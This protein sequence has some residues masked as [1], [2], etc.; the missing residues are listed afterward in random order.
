M[1][2]IL[3]ILGLSSLG[4]VGVLGVENVK[5]IFSSVRESAERSLVS[6]EMRLAQQI[7]KAEAVRSKCIDQLSEGR[8]ALANLDVLLKRQSGKAETM[9]MR[10]AGDR[11]SLES[12][13]IALAG[14]PRE[15]YAVGASSLGRSEYVREIERASRKLNFDQEH[16]QSLTS[17]VAR[18]R[19]DR[20]EVARQL[21]DRE[22]TPRRMALAIETLKCQLEILRARKAAAASQ[23][24]LSMDDSAFDEARD[25]IDRIEQ[26]IERELT[27]IDLF[28][29]PASP[30]PP[31]GEETT[32]Q[33]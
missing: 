17:V 21:L 3:M 2:R 23:E 5:A 15:S 4:G 30:P 29:T 28:S 6:L 22:D 10:L 14:P 27:K 9:S 7:R 8:A 16:L 31:P 26:E 13:R 25:L 20:D 33:R 1:K 18:L 24:G 12:H 19:Q 11:A 32:L